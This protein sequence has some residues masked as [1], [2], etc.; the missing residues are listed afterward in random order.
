MGATKRRVE[1][2]RPVAGRNEEGG[3]IWCHGLPSRATLARK[4]T[5]KHSAHGEKEKERVNEI[6]AAPQRKRRD[7]LEVLWVSKGIHQRHEH[8]GRTLRVAPPK[9]EKE[10][11]LS[12]R[13]NSLLD[14]KSNTKTSHVSVAPPVHGDFALPLNHRTLWGEHHLDSWLCVCEPSVSSGCRKRDMQG[15][16]Q[17]PTFDVQCHGCADR[18]L[19]RGVLHSDKI[20]PRTSCNV[21]GKGPVHPHGNGGVAL[22]REPGWG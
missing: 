9:K 5:L 18:V 22:Y 20:P 7:R 12:S 3:V 15:G 6:K 8:G 17:N 14:N 19:V 11:R 4:L 10:K 16:N 21:I 1:E 2:D 13:K